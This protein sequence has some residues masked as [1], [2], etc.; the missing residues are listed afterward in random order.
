LSKQELDN[1]V[2]LT[3]KDTDFN[4]EIKDPTYGASF[5]SLEKALKEKEVLTLPA[6]IL[7][8]FDGLYYGF[9]G[10]RRMNL[11][12]KGFMGFIL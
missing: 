6:P 8:N 10:N 4:K 3:V 12:W 5:K 11:A 1:A 9:A 2:N 7:I